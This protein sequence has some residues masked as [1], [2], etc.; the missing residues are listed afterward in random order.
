MQGFLPRRWLGIILVGPVL[1]GCAHERQE[2]VIGEQYL[3]T[4]TEPG[5]PSIPAKEQAAGWAVTPSPYDSGAPCAYVWPVLKSP[6]A[7]VEQYAPR[8][9]ADL[10]V[11]AGRQGP[12]DLPD[13]AAEDR[14]LAQ[15]TSAGKIVVARSEPAGQHDGGAGQ[16]GPA[17]GHA[18]DYTWLIG[19]LDYLYSRKTWIVRYADLDEEDRY[20]GSV[21]LVEDE[22]VSLEQFRPGQTVRV[23]GRVEDRESDGRC[24]R[25]RVRS[26]RSLPAGPVLSD[27][28]ARAVR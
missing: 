20:G 18:A 21:T 10:P 16:P 13:P 24:P 3:T 7:P 27:P 15:G 17:L 23:E 12:G 4:W 19:K 14:R 9:L 11:I 2:D 8:Q 6:Y 25:Y 28:S 22:C 1:L 5:P 26:L